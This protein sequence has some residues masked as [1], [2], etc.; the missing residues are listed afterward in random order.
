MSAVLEDK[1]TELEGVGPA[2]TKE[3]MLAM[4]GKTRAAIHEIAAAVKLS[5]IH[6]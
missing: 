2:F 4:R 1:Q 5:L 6:I 3:Q